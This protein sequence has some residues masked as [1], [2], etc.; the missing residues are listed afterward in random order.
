M[1]AVTSIVSSCAM[2]FFVFFAHFNLRKS[3]TH[4]NLGLSE[5]YAHISNHTYLNFS[6]VMKNNVFYFIL[7]NKVYISCTK[8]QALTL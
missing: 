2:F 3:V 6:K 5:Y 7:T 8:K 4:I 1:S